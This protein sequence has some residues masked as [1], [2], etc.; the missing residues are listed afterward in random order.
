MLDWIVNLIALFFILILVAV[1]AVVY[2]P[3]KYS[4]STMLD[5]DSIP[6]NRD[7]PVFVGYDLDELRGG[8]EFNVDEM[9]IDAELLEGSGANTLFVTK[10]FFVELPDGSATCFHARLVANKGPK[11]DLKVGS[12]V[13]LRLPSS[14][15]QQPP[16][17]TRQGTV[18]IST[19]NDG[20]KLTAAIL[21]SVG[22]KEKDQAVKDLNALLDTQEAFLKNLGDKKI[23][24][25]YI[26]LTKIKLDAKADA[27][28][29]TK[30]DAKK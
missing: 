13:I 1:G 14:E 28:T 10:K 23:D 12:K 22:L 24:P 20:T 11:T 18:E 30:T 19:V 15:I 3:V 26:V 27:K 21:E 8:G 5:T 4:V 16:S 17:P 7:I 2:D 29:D 25:K 6:V 9:S